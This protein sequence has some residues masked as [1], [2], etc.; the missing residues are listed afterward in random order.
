MTSFQIK[1]LAAL[2]MVVDHIGLILFPHHLI[3]RYMGRLSFP[4]FAWLIGQGEK[5]TK[6]FESYTLRL[7]VAAIISQ[8]V[9]HA[10]FKFSDLNILVSLLIGLLAIRV[11]K[12][13]KYK[14]LTWL[15]FAAIAQTINANY[16]LYGILVI[17]GL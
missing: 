7:T 13:T 12:L 2:L 9:Y 8:P 14:Y 15:T 5:Y 11:G 3:F 4:L 16:G 6:N 17:T 10:L 1:V